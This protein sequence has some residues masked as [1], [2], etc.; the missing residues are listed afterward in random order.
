[1]LNIVMYGVGLW[2][3]TL[4]RVSPNKMAIFCSSFMSTMASNH[5]SMRVVLKKRRVHNLLAL[6]LKRADS[7]QGQNSLLVNFV[8]FV[9]F[10]TVD[11][12][13]DYNLTIVDSCQ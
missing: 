11:L 1:M 7:G 8:N 6:G 4:K 9:N 2:T 5:T 13:V 10:Y 3:S 12:I